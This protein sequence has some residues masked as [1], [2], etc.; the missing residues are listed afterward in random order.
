M[1]YPKLFC[2]CTVSRDCPEAT[3]LWAEGTEARN[4]GDMDEFHRLR[5]EWTN[6]KV[7][8]NESSQSSS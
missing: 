3:R 4:R 8:K 5:A 2:G 7:G 6:H 1:I